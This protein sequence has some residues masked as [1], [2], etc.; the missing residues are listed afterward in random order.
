MPDLT[1]EHYRWCQANE[2]WQEDVEGSK[3]AVYTVTF[4][5]RQNI[6]TDGW[7]C[8]CPGFQFRRAC[9]HVAAAEKKKCDYG[10]SAAWGSPEPDDSWVGEEHCC[11]QC[12]GPS[13][14]VRVAV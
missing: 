1:I 7:H 14:I 6:E 2:Y 5:P 11:P 13:S 12:G 4:R 9:K 8:T 3:G 10:L